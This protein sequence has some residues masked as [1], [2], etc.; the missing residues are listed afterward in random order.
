MN[1][2]IGD[3]SHMNKLLPFESDISASSCLSNCDLPSREGIRTLFQAGLASHLSR[4]SVS[5]G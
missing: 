5:D 2:M 1:M 3:R 4:C